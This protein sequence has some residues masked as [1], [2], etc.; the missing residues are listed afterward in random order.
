M[1]IKYKI[2]TTATAPLPFTYTVRGNKEVV[3]DV[4]L[5]MSKSSKIFV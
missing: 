2:Y 5:G 3:Q 1:N 4:S